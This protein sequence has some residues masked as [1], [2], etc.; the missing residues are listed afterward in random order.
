MNIFSLRLPAKCPAA[1]ICSLT[2][3]GVT[4]CTTMS[5]PGSQVS[6]IR[7]ELSQLQGNPELAQLVPTAINEAEQAL[8]AVER[9]VSNAAL[10]SHLVYIADHK[11]NIARTQAQSRF[12]VEQHKVLSKARDDARL[13]ARTREADL[14]RQDARDARVDANTAKQEKDDAR[15]RMVSAQAE[16]AGTRQQTEEL[17][18]QLKLLKADKTQRGWVI[19]LGDVLFATDNASL[20]SVNTRHLDELAAF[21]TKY[22][23]QSALIEGHTDNTGNAAYNQQLSQHRADAVRNFMLAQG[24]EAARLS[25]SGKGESTPV[26]DNTTAT[27]RQQNRRVEVIIRESVLL[28]VDH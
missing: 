24:I 7:T 16:V 11:V 19:T 15:A 8:Q 12:A 22:P 17:Q 2:L 1:L 10:L 14:A 6:D 13:Q 28:A 9:P 27:G 20:Q 21:L 23:R 3:A 25:S 26:A 5:K 4:A 18:D